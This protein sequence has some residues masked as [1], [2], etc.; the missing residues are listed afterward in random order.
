MVLKTQPMSDDMA[1]RV[2]REQ[3]FH[4]ETEARKWEG[5]KDLVLRQW[6]VEKAIIACGQEAVA[7]FG[8]DF[9][10][11]DKVPPILPDGVLGEMEDIIKPQPPTFECAVVPIAEDILR[12]I[13]GGGE[14]KL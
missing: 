13:T 9:V 1:A 3:T 8:R 4:V 11:R 6:C 5:A 2:A 12:S 14:D 10:I 7:W